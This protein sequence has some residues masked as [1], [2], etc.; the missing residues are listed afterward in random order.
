VVAS[1]VAKS[2]EIPI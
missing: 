2:R 1:E